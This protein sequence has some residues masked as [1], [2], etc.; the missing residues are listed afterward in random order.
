[1]MGS[2]VGDKASDIIVDQGSA[3]SARPLPAMAKDDN[4]RGSF[5]VFWV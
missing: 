5:Y 4:N 3:I 2:A 1:M